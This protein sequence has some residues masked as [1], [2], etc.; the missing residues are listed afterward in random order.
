MP[1]CARVIWP[2]LSF[3]ALGV[4]SVQKV[5]DGAISGWTFTEG[6][7]KLEGMCVCFSFRSL[8]LSSRCPNWPRHVGLA[9]NILWL[10]EAELPKCHCHRRGGVNPGAE[11]AAGCPAFLLGF[12]QA[13]QWLCSLCLPS[14]PGRGKQPTTPKPP[15]W[16]PGVGDGP[17]AAP[18]VL[19]QAVRRG[20]WNLRTGRERS[21]GSVDST[22]GTDSPLTLA[23][24]SLSTAFL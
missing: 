8:L 4:A 1:N 7:D 24:A 22:P 20:T 19:F 23:V 9:W 2:L 6:P 18:R 10:W 17:S 15:A 16:E 14:C 3:L 11:P 12:L 5:G 21:E 13:L